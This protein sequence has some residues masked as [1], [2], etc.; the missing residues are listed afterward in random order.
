MTLIKK[1]G[2]EEYKFVKVNK[3]IVE[4]LLKTWKFI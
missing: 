4:K 1:I 2:D 3:N